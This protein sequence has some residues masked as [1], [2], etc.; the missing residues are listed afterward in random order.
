MSDHFHLVNEPK[1]LASVRRIA[2]PKP[3]WGSKANLILERGLYALEEQPGNILHLTCAHAGSG[4]VR[5]Y[6]A[7]IV[8]DRL[9]GREIWRAT[10]MA[11]GVWHLNAGF[12]HGLVVEV[13]GGVEGVAPMFTAVWNTKPVAGQGG[14]AQEKRDAQVTVQR[15][16][17]IMTD[18]DAV[19]YAVLMTTAG[20]GQFTI[21]DGTGRPLFR[22]PS[23]FPGS[24]ILEHV[25]ARGG[26]SVDVDFS[27][28]PALTLSW[29][30]IGVMD[31]MTKMSRKDSDGGRTEGPRDAAGAGSP[32]GPD[33]GDPT[34]GNSPGGAAPGGAGVTPGPGDP[35]APGPT[36][37]GGAQG[38]GDLAGDRRPV[39]PRPPADLRRKGRR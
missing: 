16:T 21:R 30:D 13:I 36:R 7:Q 35:D 8:A 2:L 5:V 23:S 10:P 19:L 9:V 22:M 15:G 3:P 26:L 17:Q 1:P 34:G 37:P 25:F 14:A 27:V 6:D 12:Q 39:A 32:S 24:F 4:S 33:A 29:Y 11:M 18:R 38:G 31:A 20:S 28:P